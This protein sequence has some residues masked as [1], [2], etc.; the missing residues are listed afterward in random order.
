MTSAKPSLL[1]YRSL[2][3][4]A[5]S[6]TLAVL[7]LA[8]SSGE[9]LVDRSFE[10][11]FAAAGGA[12]HASRATTSDLTSAKPSQDLWLTHHDGTQAANT[13]LQSRI[14]ERITMSADGGQPV[15]LEVI[16]VTEIATPMPVVNGG[17]TAPRLV[18]VTCREVGRETGGRI[19]RVILDGDEPLPG[20]VATGPS[21]AL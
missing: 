8:L 16:G 15:E 7:L 10:T 9:A 20:A 19:V 14:G 18:M 5:V 3:F 2:G 6:S 1:G 4:A 11:A 13:A 12:T 17:T 21:R